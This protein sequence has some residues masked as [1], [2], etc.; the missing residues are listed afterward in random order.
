MPNQPT[1]ARINETKSYMK[2][3]VGKCATQKYS[4]GIE[5]E[6]ILLLWMACVSIGQGAHAYTYGLSP[7]GYAFSC[8]W[9]IHID[10]DTDVYSYHWFAI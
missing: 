8:L 4:P 9:V 3:L 5:G 7:H 10:V 1:Y 2:S 6:L